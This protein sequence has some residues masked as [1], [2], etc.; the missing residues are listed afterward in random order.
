MDIILRLPQPTINA[1]APDTS[2]S[3]LTTGIEAPSL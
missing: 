2:L 1:A 3:V